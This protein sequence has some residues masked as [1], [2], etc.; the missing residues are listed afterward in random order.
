MKPGRIGGLNESKG[1]HLVNL[2]LRKQEQQQVSN[3][4]RVALT[5]GVSRPWCCRATSIPMLVNFMYLRWLARA[6]DRL[7][8]YSTVLQ[9]CGTRKIMAVSV[10][11]LHVLHS[12]GPETPQGQAFVSITAPSPFG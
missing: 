1:L 10:W 12:L 4:R 3:G 6:A 9:K 8:V 11:M 5:A 7:G 2:L